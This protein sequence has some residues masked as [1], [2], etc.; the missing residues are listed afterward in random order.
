M[1][2]LVS[3]IIY[4]KQE[5]ENWQQHVEQAFETM[6]KIEDLATSYNDSSEVGQLNL[7]AGQKAISVHKEL[8]EIIKQAQEVGEN[9]DGAFDVT[10]LPL[11]RLWN[12]K[13]SNP[14]VPTHDEVLEKRGLVDFRRIV[15][16]DNKVFLPEVNMGVDLGAIA[17]GYAVD[18]AVE[19]LENYDYK[20]FMVE[21]GGDL[22]AVADTLT[23]GQRT[24]WVRHPRKSG[25]FF[26][27]IKMD[28]GAVASSGDYE[29]F[30]EVSGKRFH[31]IVN[32]KTGYPASPTV[33][34][35]I[36]SETTALAD[37]YATA[38]FVL[39]PEKG[40]DFIEK[41]PET[42][43]LIIYQKEIDSVLMLDWKVSKGIAR[44]LEIID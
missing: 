39:G 13:S 36:F 8:L 40:L 23:Q 19:V 7:N 29:R 14:R 1:D 26:A 22:R 12:F 21:A 17:K 27:K 42:E 38:V 25:E 3:I 24:I 20:D 10:V 11:L 30:F 43:G 2:T 41:L 6:Q 9:S 35:T 32:P 15:I 16:K 4:A 28:E 34:V 33:S 18:R 44:D 5:P 31:H 37:A